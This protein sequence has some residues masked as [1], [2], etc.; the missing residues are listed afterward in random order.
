MAP[1]PLSGLSSQGTLRFGT[2]VFDQNQ[3]SAALVATVVSIGSMI[4]YQWARILATT[5]KSD[6]RAIMAMHGALSSTS[7]QRAIFGALAKIKLNTQQHELLELV[8]RGTAPFRSVR[9]T[10][11]HH[12]WGL[13]DD[14]PGSMLLIDPMA[15]INLH[16]SY[17]E[18]AAG[19]P[20]SEHRLDR[21]QIL[22]YSQADLE[23]VATEARWALMAIINLHSYLGGPPVTVGTTDEQMRTAILSSPIVARVLPRPSPK[24]Q[25]LPQTKRSPQKPSSS[26]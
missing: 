10:F 4:D 13:A 23:E 20:V 19:V 26:L 5:A 14:I 15:H 2:G 3:R 25:R 8:Q 7:A 21:S 17:L 16:V 11:C 12:L 9:N 22:V 6:S 24:K 1:K 18:E